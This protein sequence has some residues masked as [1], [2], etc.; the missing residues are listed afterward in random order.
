MINH[1][2]TDIFSCPAYQYE[3]TERRWLWRVPE[4]DRKGM[5]WVFISESLRL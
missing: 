3:V 1:A 5:G 2:I 4:T